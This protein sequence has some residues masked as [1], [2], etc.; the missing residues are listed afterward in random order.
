MRIWP[1]RQ[2]RVEIDPC[3]AFSIQH[4][5]KPLVSIL[6]IFRIP[7][8]LPLTVVRGKDEMTVSCLLCPFRRISLLFSFLYLSF[9]FFSFF[10]FLF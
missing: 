6:G 10:F 5:T 3:E 8:A 9:F 2:E 1:Q 4:E 7:R